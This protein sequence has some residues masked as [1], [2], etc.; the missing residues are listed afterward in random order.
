MSNRIGGNAIQYFIQYCLPLPVCSFIM[1]LPTSSVKLTVPFNTMS[2]IVL[3][4]LADNLSVGDTKFPAA[5]FI[6][7]YGSPT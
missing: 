3:N 1:R 4:A 5:L 7:T 2:I 6:T